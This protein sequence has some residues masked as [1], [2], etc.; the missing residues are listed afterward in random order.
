MLM[1]FYSVYFRVLPLPLLQRGTPRIPRCARP[2]VAF[3]YM[4]MEDYSFVFQIFKY[5]AFLLSTF[6]FFNLANIYLKDYRFRFFNNSTPKTR[7][8]C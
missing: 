2:P 5:S 1:E 8:N 3:P 7:S 4:L 6:Q